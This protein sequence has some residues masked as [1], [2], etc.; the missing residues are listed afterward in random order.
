MRS[1]KNLAKVFF[2]IL[3]LLRKNEFYSFLKEIYSFPKILTI[4]I[5]GKL[6]ILLGK[7]NR[8][9]NVSNNIMLTILTF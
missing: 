5:K 9:T 1:L 2:W 6:H 7:K 8:R 4:L 3:I